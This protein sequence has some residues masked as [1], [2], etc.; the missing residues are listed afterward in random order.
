MN[1]LYEFLAGITSESYK[2]ESKW[3][4]FVKADAYGRKTAVYEVQ[5]KDGLMVLGR[6][7]WHSP[8]RRYSF[9]PSPDTV[10]ETDCLNDIVKFIEHLMLERKGDKISETANEKLHKIYEDFLEA[11]GAKD[12]PFEEYLYF[13]RYQSKNEGRVWDRLAMECGF[14]NCEQALQEASKLSE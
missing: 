12:G 13:V 7:K 5:S 10:F 2:E 3:I 8:W 6:V 1:K 14:V 9:F 4:R 11:G